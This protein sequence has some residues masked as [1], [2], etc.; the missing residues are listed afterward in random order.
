M[1]QW[2]YGGGGNHGY[3][4]SPRKNSILNYNSDGLISYTTYMQ[5]TDQHT[6]EVSTQIKTYYFDDANG[7]EISA[8]EAASFAIGDY[9]YISPA[10]DL[11]DL[12]TQ[13][14]AN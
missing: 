10:L 8:E 4:Y 12:H 3:E 2:S 11:A 14:K 6:L 5:I 13:L 9:I 1:D 7:R